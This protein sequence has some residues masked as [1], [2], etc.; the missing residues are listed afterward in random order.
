VSVTLL[1]GD[2]LEN[3]NGWPLSLI[4]RAKAA[5]HMSVLNGSGQWSLERLLHL[6]DG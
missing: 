4:D 3:T 2:F 1:D 6:A 5:F